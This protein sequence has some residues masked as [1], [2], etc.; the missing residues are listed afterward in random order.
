MGKFWLNPQTNKWVRWH[1]RY[2]VV[3]SHKLA[4][5]AIDSQNKRINQAQ[6]ALEKLANKPG[7]ELDVLTY[8]VEN[9]LKRHRVNDFFST[10]ITEQTRTETRHQR[11]GRPSKNTLQQQVTSTRL[12]L[13]IEKI[14]SAIVEAETLAG[15]RLLCTFL[16]LWS[17]SSGRH[18]NKLKILCKVFMMAIPNEKLLALL[19]NKCLRLFVT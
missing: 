14:D 1:E 12:Q 2:L 7:T 16:P 8:K 5:G 11:R 6:L 15:W 13:Q 10:T 17:L 3:Y 9:I 4:L 18:F 19:P